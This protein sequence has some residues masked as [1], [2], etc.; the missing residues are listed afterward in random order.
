MFSPYEHASQWR[1][2]ANSNDLWWFR[3]GYNQLVTVKRYAL[4]A[5]V[6]IGANAVFTLTG[7]TDISF[8]T[9]T[10]I[11]TIMG[12]SITSSSTWTAVSSPSGYLCYEMRQTVGPIALQ[13]AIQFILGN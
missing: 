6:T 10:V 11:A 7:Y 1:I 3:W 2:G 13:G 8:A 12:S 9:G 5:A 4:I